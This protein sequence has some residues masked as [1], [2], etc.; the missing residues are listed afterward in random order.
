MAEQLSTNYAIFKRISSAVL[1]F[2]TALLAVNLWIM[3]SNNAQ[4]WYQIESE[5]LGRNLTQQAAKMLV[6]VLE[7][8][9][10]DLLQ[11]YLTDINE[12]V[13]VKSAVLFDAQGVRLSSDDDF[14]SVVDLHISPETGSLVFV[15]SIQD[16]GQNI[17]GYIKIVLDRDKVVSHHQ[18][19]NRGQFSQTLIIVI[20]SMLIACLLTRMF[21]KFRFRHMVSEENKLL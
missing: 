21:Y 17:L 10:D 13:L 16:S 1:F 11:R 14:I 4:N 19:Y 9:Q 6:P 20:L 3:H 8:D 7:N 15:E 2:C 18:Q 12:G 5:Q